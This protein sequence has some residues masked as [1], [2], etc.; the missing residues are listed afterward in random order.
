MMRILAFMAFLMV[1]SEAFVA[2]AS[3]M[4]SRTIVTSPVSSIE[5]AAKKP[6]KKPVKKVV[7][8]AAPKSSFKPGKQMP[9]N[10]A[11]TELLGGFT[12]AFQIL[13]DLPK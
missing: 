4:L 9:A 5:M 3:P 1:S 10:Q 7:K 2:P 13:K 8:K 12:N 11:V 6:V